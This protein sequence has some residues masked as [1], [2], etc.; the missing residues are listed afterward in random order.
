[1]VVAERPGAPAPAARPWTVAPPAPAAL[2]AAFPDLHPVAIQVLHARGLGTPEAIRAFLFEDTLHDPFALRGID[3]AVARVQ[4]AIQNQ[5]LI[6]AHG[7]F[8]V[9]GVTATAVLVQG[10]SAAG[11][12]VVPYLPVRATTGYGMHPSAVDKLAADGVTLIVTADTGTRAVEAVAHAASLGV[13][14]IVTDHHLPGE[15]LPHAHAL[16]NPHQPECSYPFKELSG[17]G[18]AWKLVDALSREQPFVGLAPDDLLDLVALGTIVDVSPLVGENRW[19]VR[20]GLE[21]LAKSARPGIQAL[22]QSTRDGGVSFDERTVAFSLGPRLNAAGRMDSAD[23]ALEL[24]LT[25]DSARAFD[26]VR[27][28]EQ[29]N[30]ERQQL[31]ERVLGAAREQAERAAGQPLLFVRGQDWPGG[32]LGL[33]AARL[34]DEYQRPAIVVDIGADACRGSARGADVDF[35]QLL[36]SCADLLI[37]YGGHAQA[38]G[39]ALKTARLDQLAERLLAASAGRP[40]PTSLPVIADHRLAEA[41]LEWALY[42]GLRCLRPFGHGN[43]APLFLT[44][45]VRLLEARP[46]G[47]GAKHLRLRLRLGRQTLTAFG[48]NLGQ[49]AAALAAAS[50]TDLLYSLESATW[51]GTE[52]LE[53]RLQDARPATL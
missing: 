4:R 45:A 35:V 36:A 7:D 16:V 15:T 20:R 14:V 24:L 30:V 31:T 46:V 17:V 13:D 44:E 8:D 38:A 47:A 9:D 18:V 27:L 42:H 43:P 10:F 22:V 37:E 39:F 6:A 52:S 2:S 48:P 41:D 11:A 1:M 26:L 53:L 32:V 3:R 21:R 51:N 33:V 29:K 40:D 23:V 34:S 28:L 49:R 12:Q 19:L 25:S 50:A 5:E